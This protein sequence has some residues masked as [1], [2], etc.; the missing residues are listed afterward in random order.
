MELEME[1]FKKTYKIKR[2][3]EIFTILEDNMAVLSAQKTTAFYDS[4]KPTIERWEN[5][6]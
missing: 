4:F 6:L 3:E 5:C 1:P 2:T